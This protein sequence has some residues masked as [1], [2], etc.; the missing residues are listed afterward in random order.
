MG[1]DNTTVSETSTD[2]VSAAI[3]NVVPEAHHT[4]IVPSNSGTDVALGD[5]LPHMLRDGGL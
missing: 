3:D 2:L 4:A 5:N 1:T